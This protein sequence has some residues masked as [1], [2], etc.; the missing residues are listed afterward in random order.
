MKAKTLY[1]QLEKDFIKPKHY[2]NWFTY[3]KDISEYL[4]ENFKKKSIGLVCDFT[5]TITHVF[6]SVFPSPSVLSH[7]LSTS[8]KNA[9]LFLHHP[10][11]WDLLK[12]PNVFQPINLDLLKQLK[13]RGI[14][15]FSLHAPL[16]DFGKYSTS[17]T[18]GNALKIKNM[19][20][21]APYN[22]GL[23]GII[24]ETA[25]VTVES[26]SKKYTEVLGH[27]TS[28][29]K[30]GSDEEIQ[31]NK[32]AIVAGG[33]NDV[34][35][36]KDVTKE[37]INTFITGVT[38][39]NAFSAPVHEFA[40]EKGI[41]LLGGT[42]YSTEKFACIAM[43]EYFEKLGIHSEFIEDEPSFYDLQTTLIVLY[44]KRNSVKLGFMDVISIV[45]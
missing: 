29:Y 25:E 45:Q 19:K 39:K 15:I 2:D 38:V 43:C 23:S 35:V 12:D 20:A 30:Y 18:L 31:N 26:L 3:L 14:S 24:G 41:N 7:I 32:V 5:E 10:M 42:H 21:F 33:G 40:K 34:V 27:K 16:D 1:D 9:L 44:I 6:T 28:L 13:D 17:V 36:L 22:G 8:H 11:T 37:G 4:T